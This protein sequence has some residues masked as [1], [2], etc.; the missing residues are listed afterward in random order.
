MK[1][2][3]KKAKRVGKGFLWT[4]LPMRAIDSLS[5]AGKSV[6]RMGRMLKNGKAVAPYDEEERAPTADEIENAKL[7]EKG[8]EYFL[9]L[10]EHERFEMYYQDLGWTPEELAKQ[11]KAISRAHNV[12]LLFF[13]I[14]LLVAPAVAWRFGIFPAFYCL[15]VMVLLGVHCVKD[16]GL[17][18]QIEERAFWGIKQLI[19]RPKGFLLKRALWFLD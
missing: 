5:Q 11:K 18:T 19:L 8:R 14:L 7:L 16:A 3:G 9:G 10:E 2:L 4:L 6:G 13:Y 15:I 17:Y 1:D 12:R